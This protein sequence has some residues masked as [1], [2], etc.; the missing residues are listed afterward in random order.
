MRLDEYQDRFE[1]VRL[2]RSDGIL[3][4]TL[5]SGGGSMIWG[6]GPHREL[7]IAF[8][9]IGSD[10]ETRVVVLTGAGES[11][12]ADRDDSL[13]ALR[14]SPEGWNRI[15]WEGKRLIGSLLA[16]EVPIV[17]A[18]NGPARHHA[19]LPVVCDIVLASE[20]ATFEDHAHFISGVVP[21]DGVQVVWP[22]VLGL[23]RG[24]YFL[25]TGQVLSSGEALELGVVSE[26]LAPDGLLPRAH[27]LAAQIAARPVLATRYARIVLTE[28]LR[29]AMADGLGYG[30]ALEGLALMPSPEGGEES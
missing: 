5:H 17:A 26:V 4:V 28:Q 15:Y 29:R 3:E 16:I 20:T 7:S 18:V 19:E 13:S 9:A 6:T 30:L 14:A 11:F 25:L 21:G 8:D 1:H 12:C 2:R 27:E 10:P 23:N 22:A 24:R